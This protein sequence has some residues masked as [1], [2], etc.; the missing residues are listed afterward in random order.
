MK[1]IFDLHNIAGW[2]S[3]FTVA[4]VVGGSFVTTSCKPTEKEQLVETIDSF[5]TSYFNWRFF[6]SVKY[7]T[8]ESRR[9]LSYMVSQVSQ[10]DI[11]TLRSLEEAA[12]CKIGLIDT[13][14]SIAVADVSVSNFLNMDSIGKTGRIV[15]EATFKVPLVNRNGRWMVSLTSP[16]RASKD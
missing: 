7:C 12:T 4:L 5:S 13:H 6:Q 8:P 1:R 10:S 11:D 16:L 9:W 2:L 15:E 14:D 3:V